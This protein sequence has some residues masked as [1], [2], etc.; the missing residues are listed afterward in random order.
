MCSKNGGRN[1]YTVMNTICMFLLLTV[2][3][4]VLHWDNLFEYRDNLGYSKYYKIKSY[5]M[6]IVPGMNIAVSHIHL[7]DWSKSK[8]VKDWRKSQKISITTTHMISISIEIRVKRSSKM[9]LNEIEEYR[10]WT[11]FVEFD[12]RRW[13]SIELD[14]DSNLLKHVW[15]WMTSSN[16]SWN[17]NRF[18]LQQQTSVE[19]N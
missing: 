2:A 6:I 7:N 1:G 19:S 15:F 10:T 4:A 11:E 5:A 18:W 9:Q 14:L 3:I 16:T 17:R 8:A 12:G 13:S